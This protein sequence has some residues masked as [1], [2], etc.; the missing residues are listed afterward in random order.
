MNR[1]DGLMALQ[2]IR[3]I[4]EGEQRRINEEIRGYPPPIP[5]CDAQFNGLLE[6]R[7]CVAQALY[8]LDAIARDGAMSAESAALASDIWAAFD[9][10]QGEA[11]QRVRAVLAD[12]RKPFSA[13]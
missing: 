4:L 9:L 12:A 3:T 7:A 13:M 2:A 11:G 5:R 1:S 6:E 8:D 10:L